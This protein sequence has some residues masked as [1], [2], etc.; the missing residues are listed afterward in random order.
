M[1][2]LQLLCYG[3]EV[4]SAL[5]VNNRGKWIRGDGEGFPA[6]SSALWPTAAR[7]RADEGH[8][9]RVLIQAGLNPA[10]VGPEE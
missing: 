1:L 4:P 9:G 2:K 7:G 6:E 8:R 5:K 3:Q 10:F